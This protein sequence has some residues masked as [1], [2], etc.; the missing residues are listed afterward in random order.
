ML[1]HGSL[2]SLRIIGITHNSSPWCCPPYRVPE[3]QQ[4]C[5]ELQT[6]QAVLKE[7]LDW[8]KEAF[9]GRGSGMALYLALRSLR[10]SKKLDTRQIGPFVISHQINPVAFQLCLPAMLW[11][12]PILHQAL[13]VLPPT[14]SSP[15][16][17]PIFTTS[18]GGWG[19]RI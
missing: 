13:L 1:L 6:I 9:A 17:V 7:Q 8:A 2:H 11:V 14:T 18:P 19:E 3:A 4:M 16:P 5:Q 12:H 15:Y 10:L